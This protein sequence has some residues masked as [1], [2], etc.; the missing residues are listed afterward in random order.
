MAK[1]TLKA[2]KQ[3]V[4]VGSFVE[5]TI[6][7]RDASGEEFEGEI[8]VKIPSHDQKVNALDHWGLEDRKTATYDQSTKAILF[9]VIY[10]S[11][12]AR[13]FPTIQSTGEVSTEILN[14]M[15]DAADEV[16][17]FSG[18]KWI[19]VLKKKDGANSSSMESAEKP[20]KKPSET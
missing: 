1:L 20:S 3:A 4:G 7:F 11:E 12:D 10:S 9:E 15:Y 19:S 13:F 5:K 18:K 2:A 16:I 6:K 17:D 14:A 8:L